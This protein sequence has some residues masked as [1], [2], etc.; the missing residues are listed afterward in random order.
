MGS[1]GAGIHGQARR[2]IVALEEPSAE[3]PRHLAGTVFSLR[4]Q[5]FTKF[6]PLTRP[7][8]PGFPDLAD[9]PQDKPQSKV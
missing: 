7:P 3:V 5:E 8:L 6:P 2:Q 4:L 1:R 9:H